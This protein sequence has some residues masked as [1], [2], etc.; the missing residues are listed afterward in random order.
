MW[1]IYSALAFDYHDNVVGAMFLPWFLHYFDQKKYRLA[2]VYFVL[3]VISKE[4]MALWGI[5]IAVACLGKYFSDKSARKLAFGLAIITTFY[6]IVVTSVIMPD[7]NT[8]HRQFAQLIRYQ[9]LGNSAG[10]ILQYLLQNPQVIFQHLF[11]NTTGNSQFNNIKAELY[12]MVLL[13]GGVAFM[14][15]PW[16]LFMLFPVF[17]QKLLT[18]DFTLWGINYQY[19]VEFAPVLALAT[20]KAS[21][22]FKPNNQKR[23]LFIFLVLTLAATTVTLVK[24]KS[25]WFIKP[26]VQFQRPMH[27]RS[28]FDREKLHQTLKLIP[29]GVSVS[30]SSCLTPRLVKREKLYHFPVIRDA[31]YLALVKI[32]EEG[33]YPLTPEAYNQKLTQLRLNPNFKII[34]E[35]EQA[36]LFKKDTQ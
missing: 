12:S 25:K 17:A 10:S 13:S 31:E 35:D 20:F 23:F 34:Y 6:F 5:F 8:T 33:T 21:T 7:L 26:L 11:F 19:S 9:H 30:A 1:G 14:F 32:T 27:Y 24:R 18:H 36:I 29:D 4:N 16:Y 28:L 2:A 15:R 3:L 22:R